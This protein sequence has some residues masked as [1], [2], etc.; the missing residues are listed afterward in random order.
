MIRFA[1]HQVCPRDVTPENSKP[2]ILTMTPMVA[3]N[4]SLWPELVRVDSNESRE[5]TIPS[6]D[7]R[8]LP[9]NVYLLSVLRLRHDW[10]GLDGRSLEPL[11]PDG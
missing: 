7:A 8:S 2:E 9:G 11:A 1:T 4:S 6:V 3:P 5:H 10:L